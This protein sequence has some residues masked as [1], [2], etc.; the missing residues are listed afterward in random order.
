MDLR[1]LDIGPGR[2]EHLVAIDPAAWMEE[3]KRNGKFLER[4]GDRLPRA[5]KRE[6]ETLLARLQATVS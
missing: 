5:L 2:F 4:F 3:A 6:H 1:G